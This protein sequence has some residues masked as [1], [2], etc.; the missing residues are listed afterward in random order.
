MWP[1]KIRL[2]TGFLS[3]WITRWVSYVEENLRNLLEAFEFTPSLW[4]CSGFSVFYFLCMFFGEF[5]FWSVGL[6]FLI[7]NHRVVSYFRFIS[8]NILLISVAIFFFCHMQMKQQVIIPLHMNWIW[9]QKVRE[10]SRVSS[11]I[12]PLNQGSSPE[13]TKLGL[14]II[15]INDITAVLFK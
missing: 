7:F 15:V 4:W 11:K 13:S 6:F 9:L 14:T 3:T 10:D 2:I 5:F 12:I 1:K 8:Y